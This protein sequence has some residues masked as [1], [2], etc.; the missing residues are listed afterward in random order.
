M[1]DSNQ[2]QS[3]SLK[4]FVDNVAM[5]SS[6]PGGGSVSAVVASLGSALACM[7]SLLTYGNRAYEKLDE[8]IRSVLPSFYDTYQELID[9]CDQDGNAFTSYLV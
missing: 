2:Y 9:L 7:G 8:E 5:R 1:S 3:M 6:L 4:K